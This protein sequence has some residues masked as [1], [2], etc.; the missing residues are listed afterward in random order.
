MPSGSLSGSSPRAL[1]SPLPPPPCLVFVL[2]SPSPPPLHL[3]RPPRL[4]LLIVSRAPV[5]SPPSSWPFSSFSSR[6]VHK[7][8]LSFQD[9]GDSMARGGE[10]KEER[11]KTEGQKSSVPTL[12]TSVPT[13]LKRSKQPKALIA[14]DAFITRMYR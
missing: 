5:R 14:N 6:P 7:R 8:Q 3:R 10:R 12:Q 4:R 11:G 1:P 9:P 2:L 13:L